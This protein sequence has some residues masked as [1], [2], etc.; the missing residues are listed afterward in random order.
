MLTEQLRCLYFFKHTR[1]PSATHSG[2]IQQCFGNV[3]MGKVCGF[4]IAEG[5]T[6]TA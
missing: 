6:T 1:H 5:H 2:N 3:V 4:D